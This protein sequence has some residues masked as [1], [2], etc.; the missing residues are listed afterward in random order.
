[1]SKHYKIKNKKANEE[2]ETIDEYEGLSKKEIYDLNKKKKENIKRKTSKDKK[3]AK[4]TSSKKHP[5]NI[6]TKVFAIFMLILM[7]GSVVASIAAYIR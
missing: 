5:T 6:L 7:V 2:I 1:M 4:K 3:K